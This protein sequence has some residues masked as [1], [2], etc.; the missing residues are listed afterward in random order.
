MKEK[1][2]VA[3]PEVVMNRRT[4]KNIEFAEHQQRKEAGSKKQH[5]SHH[6]H[7]QHPSEPA[8]PS[9]AP[10]VVTKPAGPVAA[11]RA[12]A[13]SINARIMPRRNRPAGRAP[14]RRRQALQTSLNLNDNWR[15]ARLSM[16]APLP[17]V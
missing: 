12:A 16:P 14:E 4:R 13:P 17:V 2:R 8:T 7:H 1:M 5:P 6:E 9:P 10:A 11:I 15:D 3:C